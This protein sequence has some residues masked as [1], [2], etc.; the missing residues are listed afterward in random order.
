M[1]TEQ[2]DYQDGELTLEGV[3]CYQQ[4]KQPKPTVLLVHDW[5]GCRDFVVEKAKYFANKG[6]TAMGVDMYG[7]G[8]RGSSTDNSINQSLM[9]P[10]MENRAL[11]PQRLNAAL[12]F[13]R[14]LPQVDG[15][16]IV[17]I[18]FCFGGLCALDLARH[19]V[20]VNGVVSIHGL[21]FA[22]ELNSN[23]KIKAKILVL[24]GFQDPLAPPEQ[25]QGFMEEM[26]ARQ[27]DW[28]IHLYSNTLHAFTNPEAN[29]PK[30]DPEGSPPS[31]GVQFS[32]TANQRAWHA[33][34]GFCAELFTTSC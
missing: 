6:F 24:H 21:L 14:S 28:Q 8:Q 33:I 10:L 9:T 16:K 34:D 26:T 18:G 13:A 15:Q 23:A 22:P 32:P 30:F 25:V 29:S 12:T 1:K 2:V 4:D 3:L 11:I 31:F 20:E 7:K 19:G 27:A 5:S 17:V